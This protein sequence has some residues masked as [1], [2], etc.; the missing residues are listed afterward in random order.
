MVDSVAFEA[1]LIRII[2]EFQAMLI[3]E[4]LEEG[5]EVSLLTEGFQTTDELKVVLR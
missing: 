5:L 3:T 1:L 2:F 4:F